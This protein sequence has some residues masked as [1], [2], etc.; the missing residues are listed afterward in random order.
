[1]LCCPNLAEADRVYPHLLG[2]DLAV[3]DHSKLSRK[4]ETLQ[5]ALPCRGAAPRTRRSW[6]KLHIGVDTDTRRIAAA[7][8]STSG[9][10]D[11]SQVGALPDQGGP[12][13][14]FTADATHDERA[15]AP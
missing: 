5:V 12:L 7:T 11:A 13:A 10:D 4:A 1:M 14:S 9:I 8:L 2:L 6:R 3:L 15:A